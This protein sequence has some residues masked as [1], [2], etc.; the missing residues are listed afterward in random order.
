[1]NKDLKII[2]TP[3]MRSAR[4][5]RIK[6]IELVY[7]EIEVSHALREFA[8]GKTFYLRTYGCQANVRDSE[9]LAGLLEYAGFTYTNILEKAD[10]IFL[11]TCAIRE[12]AEDKVFGEIGSLKALKVENP[13]LI[14][15][16]GGCMPQ[17]EHVVTSVKTKYPQVD[18]VFGTHN[19]HKI[20]DLMT[21]VIEEK[22]RVIDVESI[23]GSVIETP[24]VRRLDDKKA[25][26]NIIYGCDKFCTYCIVPYTRGRERSR[27]KADIIAECQ[28]LIDAGY[29]EITLLGQNV[30]AYGKDRPAEGDFADLLREVAKLGI[31]R[32]RFV[33][34]HP[35]DFTSQMIDVIASYPNIMKA[36]HLP[37]QSGSDEILRRMGRRYSR[38]HY[39]KLV[40]EMRAKIP[41]IAITTDIIVGFP[42]ETKE[43][44]EET[45]T[46]VDAVHYDGAFT[47]I[48]SPRMGTPAAKMI[49][50]VTAEEKH[51]RYERLIQHTEASTTASSLKMVGGT[52]A[53]L[54]DGVS[55]RN[56]NRLS[57]YTENGKLVHFVGEPALV[58]QIVQVKII[59]SKV[60]SLQGEYVRA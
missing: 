42:G 52:Y 38:E 14:I 58:G 23:Q 16:L 59:D 24:L 9:N 39:L 43:Q 12:N 19:I 20:L 1:M 25:Y 5:R 32:L 37:V 40:A 53:V 4:D 47:F 29:Q 22:T 50:D 36:I 45:L 54:V 41:D 15:G 11:N 48:Y 56:K 30:N 26:V 28:I 7:P 60:Y 55:K 46:L 17:Q 18:I 6:P 51:E 49:D 31:P 2:A 34:S 21:T 35:W 27:T 44:F 13:N 3:D 33:T 57:G 8:R 10:V